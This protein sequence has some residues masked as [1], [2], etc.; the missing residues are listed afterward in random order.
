M[1]GP[2]SRICLDGTVA[3][4]FGRRRARAGKASDLCAVDDL[5][6]G[7]SDQ[8]NGAKLLAILRDEVIKE[9]DLVGFV[10]TG[11][12]A[13]TADLQSASTRTL[14]HAMERLGRRRFYRSVPATRPIVGRDPRG[15]RHR[16]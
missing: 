13:V 12:S 1:Y 6:F 8:E 4:R 14:Q 10:S 15:T 3:D 2:T 16:V 11:P 7:A 5:G 9:S